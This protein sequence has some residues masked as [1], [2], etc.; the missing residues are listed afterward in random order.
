MLDFTTFAAV[1]MARALETEREAQREQ[2]KW[3][4]VLRDLD[5][6]ARAAA[7]APAR[8]HSGPAAPG[9]LAGVNR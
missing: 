2:R 3:L 6:A 7:K 5:R 9:S 1:E 8:K 4:W